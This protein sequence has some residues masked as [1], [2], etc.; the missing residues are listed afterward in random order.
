[1]NIA[2]QYS[3]K[4]AKFFVNNS[5]TLSLEQSNA[6]ITKAVEKILLHLPDNNVDV[7]S[8]HGTLEGLYRIRKG[9]V[10][11][12]FSLEK[13]RIVIATIQ[14]IGFRGSVYQKR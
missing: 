13:E 11:I 14:T 9:S 5:S 6:L 2:I 4:A 3:K 12:I 10:R 7:Q 1:M 8:L